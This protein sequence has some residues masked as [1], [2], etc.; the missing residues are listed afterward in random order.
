MR[1][2]I[3]PRYTEIP[4]IKERAQAGSAMVLPPAMN[5]DAAARGQAERDLAGDMGTNDAG[6]GSG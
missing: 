4:G 3:R 1:F 2:S 5:A 6:T